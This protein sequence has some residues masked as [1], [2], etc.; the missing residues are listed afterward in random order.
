MVNIA[1]LLAG[2]LFLALPGV[3]LWAALFPEHSSIERW[4]WG[5]SAGLALAVIIAFSVSWIRLSLFT[6]AWAIVAAVGLVARR[7]RKPVVT[8]VSLEGAERW[9]LVILVLVAITRFVPTLVQAVPPGLDPSFHS[10]LAKKLLLS[11]RLFHDWM[12]FENIVLNYPLGSHL[13][14][15]ILSRWASLPLHR[16]FQLLIPTL[17]VL[18]TAQVYALARRFFRSS[19]VALYSALA[20][21]MWAF[22]GSFEYY[23]WGGLPNELGI[24]FLLPVLALVAGADFDWRSSMAF[25]V[26]LAGMF[27]VHHHVALVAGICL[28]VIIAYLWFAPPEVEPIA[29]TKIRGIVLGIAGGLLL[30]SAE[31]VPEIMKVTKLA[32]T[33]ALHIDSPNSAVLMLASMGVMLLVAGTWGFVLACGRQARA[34][35][36]MLIVISLALV[37]SYIVCSP[38]YAAYSVH[39]WGQERPLLAPS[40]FL[41]DLVYFLSIFAGYALY[42]AATACRL[43]LRTMTIVGLLLA[44]ANIPMW[45]DFFRPAPQPKVWDAYA[46]IAK[47][48]PADTIVLNTDEWAP[49][50]TWRRTPAT[51]LPASEPRV[52]DNPARRAAAAIASGRTAEA[53]SVVK[54]I[55]NNER[56]RGCIVW[57]SPSGWSVVQ[58]SPS[59]CDTAAPKG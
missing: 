46:W 22:A 33:D 39:R 9:L 28:A 45:R 12:P 21:G 34:R 41:T 6:P 5:T 16:V 29:A 50:V 38:I 49:Y 30:A 1:V 32:N 18:S 7:K 17:G 24:I 3:L 19:E 42:R 58:L 51:P 40:R 27:I 56:T 15:A 26:F 8:H 59:R 54:V 37:G 47:H 20:Y 52:S 25:A 35:A 53:P 14:V 2:V 11:D 36:G 10:L 23:R 55:P 57:T 31:I 44:L 48:T 4:T 43:S 13:I